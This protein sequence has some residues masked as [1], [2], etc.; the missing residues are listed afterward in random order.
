[1]AVNVFSNPSTGEI[2]KSSRTSISNP[3]FVAGYS[4]SPAT[5][6][7]AS[8]TTPVSGTAA[9][10]SSTQSAAPTTS[11]AVVT[12]AAGANTI[13]NISTAY[14]GIQE[15]RQQQQENND[16]AE[17][18]N[19]QGYSVSPTATGAQGETKAIYNKTGKSYYI[20]PQQTQPSSGSIAAALTSGD[21][22]STSTDTST[23]NSTTTPTDLTKEN[24]SFN[25]Q[26]TQISNDEANAYNDYKTTVDQLRSGTFPLT[27]AQQTLVDATSKSFDQ[28]IRQANLKGAALASMTGGFGNKVN[29]VMGEL[30]NI[31]ST[32]ALA[33]AHLEQ[34]FQDQNYK[35]INDAYSTFTDMEKAKTERLT[36]LHADVVT[37]A[38]AQ[39]TAQL[40][41]QSFQLEQAKTINQKMQADRDYDLKI[42]Q[43]D[44]GKYIVTSDA[45]GNPIAFN[46]KSGKFENGVATTPGTASQGLYAPENGGYQ[47]AMENALVG[48]PV[49]QAKVVRGQVDR[50]LR[51]GDYQGAR[52]TIVRSVTQNAPTDQKN[53]ALARLNAINDLTE[54][55]SLLNT[56]VTRS[57]DTSILSGS[58]QK[59]AEYI[60]QLGDK[61]LAFI[62]NRINQALQ[63][64][65]RNM[66]GVAFS[67]AEASQYKNIFPDISNVNDL[68]TVKINSLLDAFNSQQKTYIGSYIGDSNYDKIFPKTVSLG[69]DEYILDNPA[70]AKTVQ[71]IQKTHPDLGWDDVMQIVQNTL[72]SK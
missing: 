53:Q 65:R 28:M 43:L 30:A 29:A 57:G 33:I 3:G 20:T 39:R 37:Q 71:D 23:G 67:A 72:T 69:P 51:D 5:A 64:Y 9:T 10:S 16:S 17:V 11:Y 50:E 41:Q 18:P 60:G 19:I 35:M 66:T 22:S 25:S 6:G 13:N 32:K 47:G 21:T 31:D 55:K 2:I 40:A 59:A 54:V 7:T 26:M 38:N 63:S 1:M 44:Q 34:G 52:E 42:R 8:T 24:T 49:S 12:P 15:G 27:P 62:G 68:N 58:I 70:A 48:M 14:Q 46:T 45:F 56:Y 36:A 4:T 61:D